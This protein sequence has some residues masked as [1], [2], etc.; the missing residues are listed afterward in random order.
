MN[1]MCLNG[2]AYNPARDLAFVFPHHARNVAGHLAGGTWQDLKAFCDAH[3]ITD[4]DLG[5][6]MQCYVKLVCENVAGFDPKDGEGKAYARDLVASGFDA[7]PF[8]AK[9]A[10]YATLGRLLT[11]DAYLGQRHG[12][13]RAED[14]G[15]A[16]VYA[17]L[18]AKVFE[19]AERIKQEKQIAAKPAIIRWLYRIFF[20]RKK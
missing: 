13:L 4:Q 2:Q 12:V 18:V 11:V 15:S 10:I 17:G 5:M 14:Q 9:V 6:A 19:D 7:V 20:A 16:I 8:A 1:Q 3:G